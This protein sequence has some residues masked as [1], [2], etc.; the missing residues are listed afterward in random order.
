MVEGWTGFHYIGQAGLKLLT[1]GDPPTSASQSTGITGISSK[2]LNPNESGTGP[3]SPQAL[4]E[5]EFLKSLA[6]SPRL[7]GSGMISSHCSLC[8]QVQ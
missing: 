1:S 4:S 3:N 2:M 7:E 6:L 5:Y 8:L